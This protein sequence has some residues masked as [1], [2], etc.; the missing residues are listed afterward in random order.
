MGQQ[1]FPQ[2]IT[3]F[4]TG[5]GPA[6]TAA[7]AAS[8][9][10]ANQK[11]TLPNNYWY[12]GRMWRLRMTGRI[13]C[14]VTTPGTARFDLRI[15]AVIAWDSLAMPLNIVAKVNVPWTLDVLLTCRAVV[16]G[17]AG[18]NLIGQGTWESEAVIASPLPTVGGSGQFILPYNTAPVVGANFDNALANTVDVFFTQ[19]VATGSMTVHQALIEEMN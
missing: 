7:A 6:L 9:I 19:T 1:N 10:L 11:I 16:G 2:L 13:S 4:C 12:V 18:S 17:V 5:D 14:A 3:P 8:C 15:G